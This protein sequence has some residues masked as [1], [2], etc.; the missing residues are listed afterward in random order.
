MYLAA[1]IG[2][3]KTHLSLYEQENEKFIPIKEKKFPSGHY[4]SLEK[5]LQEFLSPSEKIEKACFGVAGPVHEEKC[6][7]PNLAWLIDSNSLKKELK[8]QKVVLI[9]D[10]VANAYG[11][12]TLSE[13]D[14]FVLNPGK[15]FLKNN[16][17]I[18]S[19]GT[20]RGGVGL[21]FDGKTHKP[22]ASEGGHCD[23]FV[24]NKEESDLFFYLQKKYGAH[25]SVERVLSG[26][27]L[28]NIYLYLVEAHLYTQSP[29]EKTKEKSLAQII[30]EKALSKEC[31]LCEKALDFFVSFYGAEAGNSVL[32]F[33][34][35]GGVFLGGGIAPKI[36]DKL[37]TPLFMQSFI[38]KG[39]MKSLLSNVPVKVILNEET[40]LLG[41][42]YYA[43]HIL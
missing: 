5:I 20:G 37:K 23:F 10:L 15:S 3:T 26:P 24:R 43:K 39:R 25:I 16:Q 13:K 36:L 12:K 21:F 9:N 1:D 27:G 11:I 38:N 31:S 30:S 14:F 41:S 2:G 17:T 35:L 40:A 22:F 7:T 28:E 4:F 8:T 33:Y 42:A 34:A 18:V 19:A 6:E 32:K 29:L